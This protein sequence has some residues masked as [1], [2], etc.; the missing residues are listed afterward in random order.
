VRSL[1]SLADPLK[2]GVVANRAPAAPPARLIPRSRLRV[3]YLKTLVVAAILGVLATVL[4]DRVAVA[5]ATIVRGG[6]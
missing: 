1:V 2:G 6:S 4:A 5:P 3:S